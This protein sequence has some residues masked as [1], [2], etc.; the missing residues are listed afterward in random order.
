MLWEPCTRRQCKYI[1]PKVKTKIERNPQQ[2]AHL[3]QE[4]DDNDFL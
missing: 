4:E 3:Y 2:V 1:S